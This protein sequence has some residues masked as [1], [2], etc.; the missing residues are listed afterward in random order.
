MRVLMPRSEEG[1]RPDVLHLLADLHAAADLM[2]FVK[3][4]MIEP[5]EVSAGWVVRCA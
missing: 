5:L 4:M 2:H 1:Q 3:S